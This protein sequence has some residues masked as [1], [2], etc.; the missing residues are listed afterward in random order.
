[1][2]SDQRI[3]CINC[4]TLHRTVHALLP[5]IIL[6]E[7]HIPQ[8]ELYISKWTFKTYALE[9]ANAMSVEVQHFSFPETQCYEEEN[10]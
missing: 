3:L 10:I 4:L 6:S 7:N 1:M 5:S 9:E 8:L 2:P